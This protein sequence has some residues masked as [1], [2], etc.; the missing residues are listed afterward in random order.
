[1]GV[2]A[3]EMLTGKKS[4]AEDTTRTAM[5]MPAKHNV[6]D[7][8]GKVPGLPEIL[9]RFIL[10]ACAENPED[11][12]QNATTALKDLLLLA[13]SYGLKSEIQPSEK[14]KMMNLFLLYNENQ[15]LALK[16]LLEEFSTKTRKL[17]V[18]LKAADFKDI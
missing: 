2:I 7:P 6:P 14:R 11:R 16:R 5:D 9:R 15:Q 13:K 8:V 1:L 10:K 18:D 4:S 3:Y 17:G 12:Y